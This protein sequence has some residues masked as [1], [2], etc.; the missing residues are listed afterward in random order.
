MRKRHDPVANKNIVG[1][2]I[3]LLRT[4]RNLT[5]S[6]L[7]ALLSELSTKDVPYSTQLISSWEQGRR[8]P[9]SEMFGRLSHFFGVK[10]EYIRG[11]SADP[12][13]SELSDTNNEMEVQISDL[14]SL[15]GRPVFVSFVNH[16][17]EDQ[18]AIVNANE[19]RLIMRNGYVPYPNK[20][21][22]AIYTSEPD[23]AYFLSKNGKYPLDMN[24]LLTTQSN[25]IWVEMKSY[26]L[27]VQNKYNGWYRRNENNTALISSVGLVLPYEGLNVSYNAYLKKDNTK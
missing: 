23:Y 8:M 19:N 11:L 9:T 16:V 1:A 15:D 21:I 6:E 13:S 25:L 10:E 14:P 20:N 24:G 18:F 3:A 7:A 26:D 4:K 12:D 17:H 27:I 22:R 2:R 5:Q